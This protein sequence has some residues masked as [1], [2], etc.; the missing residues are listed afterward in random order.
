MVLKMFENTVARH[1]VL[2][3]LIPMLFCSLKT[4]CPIWLF[5]DTGTGTELSSC[6]TGWS[7]NG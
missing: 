4:R 5:A 6:W 2:Q 3:A 1:M 7:W